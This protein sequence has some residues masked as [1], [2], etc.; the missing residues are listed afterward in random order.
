M[1]QAY[2][3]DRLN[4]ITYKGQKRKT[5]KSLYC[6]YMA[7]SQAVKCNAK[8]QV[9]IYVNF[10]GSHF[11]KIDFK[12]AVFKGCDFWGT[13]FNRCCF[14]ETKF[15]DC[16]FVSCRFK[17]CDFTGAQFSRSII[18][19]TN[20][21][22]C[23]N[24]NIN[25]GIALYKTYPKCN[26]TPELQA[27]LNTLKSDRNLRKTKLLFISDT[28]YN[29]LNLYL[30]QDRFHSLLPKLLLELN[31]HSTSHIVTY[32]KL[33]QVLNHFTKSSII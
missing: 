12:K 23:E 32:K 28:K 30:L 22:N 15:E 9:F 24:I 17:D 33:E 2:K 25:T 10:R 27:A 29:H 26:I 16:V 3:I 19:N 8:S 31:K 11:K 1:G 20:L 21:S 6:R 18:V 5:I 7:K 4:L 14:R 13:T